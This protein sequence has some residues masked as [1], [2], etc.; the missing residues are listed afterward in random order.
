M[1]PLMRAGLVAALVSFACFPAIAADKAF[2]DD[3]LAES[4]HQARSPDQDRRGSG[5]KAGRSAQARRRCGVPAQRFPRRHGAARTDRR[6]GAD[7]H[8]DLAAARAHHPADQSGRDSRARAAA[9]ARFDRRLHRLP[10]HHQ[11]HRGGGRS[12]S[13]SAAPSRTARCGG[14]ALDTLRLSLELREV[15]EVRGQYERLR[16]QYGFRV[17]DYTVDADAA[18]PRACFQFSEEL[19]GQPHRFLALRRARRHRQAGAVGRR[20]SS[21]A[22]KAS[23]TASATTSRCAP[24]CRR[25]CMRA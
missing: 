23:S 12:R 22:S 1:F 6:S 3:A 2:Q 8:R 19:A 9:R 10:A 25:W 21:F 14:P 18:S 17:L 15:A 4:A 16:E 20:T 11:P 7:R 24:A 13:S 5:G